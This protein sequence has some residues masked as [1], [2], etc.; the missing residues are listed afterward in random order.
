MYYFLSAMQFHL[1]EV[2]SVVKLTETE[3][4]IVDWGERGR[5]GE[6]ERLIL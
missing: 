3:S 1:H 5:G 4:N 6:W 2:S